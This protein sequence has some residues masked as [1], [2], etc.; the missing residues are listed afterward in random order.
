M[1]VT[2]ASDAELV[3]AMAEQDE[4]ALRELYERHA[5]WMSARLR[6]RCADKEIVADVLQDA[7]V[8]AWQ[9]ASKF[10]GDGEVAA[11]LW[12]IAIRRLVSRLRRNTTGLM[13]LGPALLDRD[14]VD[15][16]AEEEVLLTVEYSDLGTALARISPE[17]RVVL[18]V[19][20]L[21][22]LSTREAALLLGIPQGT[23]KTRLARARASLREE[24]A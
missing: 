18:Q 12:G 17:L 10:R 14:A 5:A 11:W 20:V 13:N 2:D 23:V 24:L 9:G 4:A 7:F 19:T 15:V 6:R 22:G 8:A 1:A 21:D 16:S 3:M